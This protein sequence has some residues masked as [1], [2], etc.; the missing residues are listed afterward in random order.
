MAPIGT[1]ESDAGMKK[2]GMTG[3]GNIN[4]YTFLRAD[5]PLVPCTTSTI[6]YEG[7]ATS[8]GNVNRNDWRGKYI[9]IH[10]YEQILL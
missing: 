1:G 10:F 6:Y 9:Y 7:K 3:G 2:I 4:I 8:C 5:T